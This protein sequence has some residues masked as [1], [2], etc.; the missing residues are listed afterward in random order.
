MG[1]TIGI[2]VAVLIWMAVL[3]A[4]RGLVLGA[5]DPIDAVRYEGMQLLSHWFGVGSIAPGSEMSLDQT[6]LRAG[7]GEFLH[8][9]GAS[10]W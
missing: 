1:R 4:A 6:G 9:V 2:T 5:D 10:M 7:M 3:L 8:A